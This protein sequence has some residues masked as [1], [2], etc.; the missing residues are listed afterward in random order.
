MKT[1]SALRVYRILKI[2]HELPADKPLSAVVA[3]TRVFD[4]PF[5]VDSRNVTPEIEDVVLE[6]LRDLR[7]EVT[8]VE[9]SVAGT[10]VASAVEP[11]ANTVRYLTAASQLAMDWTQVKANYL[12]SDFLAGWYWASLSLPSE[13]DGVTEGALQQL[14]VE[15]EELE[16]TAQQEQL[17][18]ELQSFIQKQIIKMRGAIKRYD[19]SGIAPLRNAISEGIGDLVRDRDSLRE[20][21]NGSSQSSSVT[22]S[23]FKKVWFAAVQ[24]CGDLEKIQKGLTLIAKAYEKVFPL[25]EHMK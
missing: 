10:E 4:V 15:L 17:P 18:K 11:I 9:Q 20:D 14:K 24:I 2:A 3:W 19:I 6:R 16:K 13:E 25:L 1:S 23:K 7:D 22:G 12:R 8:N 21:E 5:D